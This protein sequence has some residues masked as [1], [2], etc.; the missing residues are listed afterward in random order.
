MH[1]NPDPYERGHKKCSLARSESLL[2]F[3][4]FAVVDLARH[5]VAAEPVRVAWA[6]IAVG[7]L[8]KMG[9]LDRETDE[10][11]PKRTFEWA[12]KSDAGAEIVL[13]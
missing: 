13:G 2:P 4:F 5:G 7:R 6:R 12:A 8:R 3:A 10:N 11:D 1:L 9:L